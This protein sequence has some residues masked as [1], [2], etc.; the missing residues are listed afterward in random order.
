MAVAVRVGVIYHTRTLRWHLSHIQ[1]VSHE[2]NNSSSIS[3]PYLDCCQLFNE[4][5]IEFFFIEFI[6][7]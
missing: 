4:S 1:K 7:R 5:F 3:L 2:Q 6:H